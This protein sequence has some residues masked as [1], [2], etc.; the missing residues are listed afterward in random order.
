MFIQNRKHD[1]HQVNKPLARCSNGIKKW[2]R[3]RVW[4]SQGMNKKVDLVRINLFLCWMDVTLTHKQ[5]RMCV[6]QQ[7]FISNLLSAICYCVINLPS[8]ADIKN[9]HTHYTK[10]CT[11]GWNDERERM[12]WP[13]ENDADQNVKR[14]KNE[15]KWYE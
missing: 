13:R 9:S 10:L 11:C 7:K 8:L 5:F 12:K 3:K 1:L 4:S 14:E 15:M 2:W 6:L